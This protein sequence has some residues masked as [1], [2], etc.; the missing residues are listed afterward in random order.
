MAFHKVLFIGKDLEA[1]L[2][3]YDENSREYFRAVNHLEHYRLEYDFYKDDKDF[4]AEY[5]KGTFQDFLKYYVDI[6]TI[7]YEEKAEWDKK[8]EHYALEDENGEVVA[9]NLY[10]NP[11]TQFQYYEIVHDF[12]GYYDYRKELEGE[13]RTRREDW[14]AAVKILG[15]APKFESWQDVV[16]KAQEGKLGEVEGDANM[17]EV[18]QEYYYNQPDRAKLAAALPYVEDCLG[19]CKDEREY[20][21][22]ASLPYYAILTDEGW[23]SQ[24]QGSY[25]LGITAEPLSDKEWR[26][27]Q[28]ELVKRATSI[29]GY[30]A[31]IL[32]TRI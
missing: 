22:H 4:L 18:A 11:N 24:V 20:L 6:P 30:K 7:K 16:A 25:Y 8:K 15:R 32:T 26:K 12:K 2:A 9:V 17:L 3:P 21:S 10:I 13:E 28:I 23:F 27:K 5:P 1:A 29:A 19:N 14:A 31:Y